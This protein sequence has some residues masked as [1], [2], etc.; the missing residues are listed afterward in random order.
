VHQDRTHHYIGDKNEQISIGS[1]APTSG[2]LQLSFGGTALGAPP[3][4]VAFSPNDGDER[5]LV[6]TLTGPAGSHCALTISNVD[7][8]NDV[9]ILNVGAGAFH[10][11]V[12]LEF[13]VAKPKAKKAAPKRGRI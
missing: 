4:T 9:T 13:V 11:T 8:G 7:G 12:T 1:S 5:D 6:A 2:T 3:Q 10:D